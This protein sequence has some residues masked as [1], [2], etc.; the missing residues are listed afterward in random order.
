[1]LWVRDSTSTVKHFSN[2]KGAG[3]W[4]ITIAWVKACLQHWRECGT[5][6]SK[7]ISES[8]AAALERVWAPAEL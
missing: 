8:V 3:V 1:M 5:S 7:S 6:V 2:S 4:V